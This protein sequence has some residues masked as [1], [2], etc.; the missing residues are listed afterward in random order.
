MPT[1][2]IIRAALAAWIIITNFFDNVSDLGDLLFK[3]CVALGSA[4]ITHSGI[5]TFDVFSGRLFYN[6]SWVFDTLGV[7]RIQ[8]FLAAFKV[9]L[10][11]AF[12]DVL[13]PA[14]VA[15]VVVLAGSLALM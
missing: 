9:I 8:T 7:C 10:L 2:L 13:I 3:R 14:L 4:V 1:L 15:V 6:I 5:A 12:K 11:S